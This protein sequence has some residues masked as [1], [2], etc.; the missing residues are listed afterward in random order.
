MSSRADSSLLT[1][2]RS[3]SEAAARTAVE[4]EA[5]RRIAPEVAQLLR[6]T[7]L[8]AMGVPKSVGGFEPE[9]LS[10]LEAIRAVATADGSAGWVTMIYA[11]S[12][13]AAHY[14][15]EDALA[16]VYAPGPDV[17]LAGVLA[18]RGTV[19]SSDSGNLL[20]GRWPFASGS[21]D[22]DWISLGALDPE[23]RLLS[24]ILPMSDVEVIDTWM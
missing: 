5:G 20:S 2:V 16:E 19:S 23:G 24:V 4:A 7:G 15:T 8:G 6:S 3:V 1:A 17:L 13:V 12:S 21:V 22:A 10:I 14:L 9:V 18:P 11:T